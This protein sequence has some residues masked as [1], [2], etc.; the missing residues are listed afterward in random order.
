MPWPDWLAEL[1]RDRYDNAKF[2]PVTLTD[3]T[4][5]YDSECA[6]LFPETVSVA[7][8]PDVSHFG[9]IFC[10]RE[11]ERFRRVVGAAA[12]TVGVNLPPDAAALIHS[13]ELSIEAYAMWDLIHDRAHSRGDLPFDPFMIRQ[14]MPYWMYSLEELRCDLTTF[15]EAVKLEAEGMAFARRAVRDPL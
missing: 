4:A 5:G 9:A 10:D 11:S 1:E 14:R 15:G 8:K 13:E 7:A 12:D 2:V 6:V 3:H